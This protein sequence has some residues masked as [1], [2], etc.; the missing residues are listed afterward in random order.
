MTSSTDGRSRDIG[1][2]QPPVSVRLANTRYAHRGQLRDAIDQ[3]EQ[4]RDWLR[5]NADDTGLA[6][7]VPAITEGD[8]RAFADL[9]DA[10]RALI[11]ASTEGADRT[12]QAALV[13]R[14]SA[15]LP[16]WPILVT[17]GDHFEAIERTDV[18]GVRRALGAIAQDAVALL[19]GPRRNDVQPCNA[20]GC[21]IFF[22]KDHPRREWCS[23]GC[24]NRARAARHYRRHHP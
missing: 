13:N 5:A 7:G 4:L 21:V 20:P 1:A 18:H 23:T 16:H 14:L 24:G 9:R 22:V 3:P 15:G 19:G 11:P 2:A 8:I 12:D 10:I 6:D 17:A